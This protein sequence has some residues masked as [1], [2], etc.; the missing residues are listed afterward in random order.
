MQIRW[1]SDLLKS[2]GLL[3]RSLS[4]I[5]SI[6]GIGF[7]GFGELLSN[8]I[9]D[10][11]KHYS[12]AGW[13]FGIVLTALGVA[14]SLLSKGVPEEI[15]LENYNRELEIQKLG[16]K[17]EENESVTRELIDA[18]E[19][20]QILYRTTRALYD[21]CDALE[22]SEKL[23]EEFQ[24]SILGRAFEI[25]ISRLGTLCEIEMDE[26][27]NISLY[28]MDSE[29]GMLICSYCRRPDAA[30]QNRRHRSWLPGEGH[31]GKAF[32]D[33]KDLICSDTRMPDVAG[34]FS[35]PPE[36]IAEYDQVKY[37]SIA[38]VPLM[39][40]GLREPLGVLVATSDQPGRFVN[41]P[42]GRIDS[43]EPI[44]VLADVIATL[45]ASF[46]RRN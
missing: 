17:I 23:D 1:V 28:V 39:L 21:L 41:N 24:H 26:K 45:L 6:G 40:G 15:I 37:V 22:N 3:L 36:K 4:V 33:R 14:I 11:S 5:F 7:A 38:S 8:A 16:V 32:Q 13:F 18:I 34:F 46:R 44:R 42:E 2:N 31:V 10:S 30:D 27:W 25:V 9:S 35:A 20:S 43:V 19:Y 12:E 29:T